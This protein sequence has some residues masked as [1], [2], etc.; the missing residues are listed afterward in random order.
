MKHVARLRL[1]LAACAAAGLL[2]PAAQAETF[3]ATAVAGHPEVFLWV[4]TLSDTLIP[5]VSEQLE[6]TEHSINWME[7]YG[8]TLASVGGEL[9]AIEGGLAQIGIVSSLFEPSLLSLQNVSYATPFGPADVDIVF[10]TVDEMHEEIPDM[11]ALWEE[12]DMEYLGGG[13]GLEDYLLMTDFPVDSLDDLQGRKINAPGPAVNWLKGTGAVG[14]SGNLT[15][16][17]NDIQTGV[18]EGVIVFPTAAAAAKLHEVAPY[19]TRVGFG[20][21]YA[22]AIVAKKSW[23][24]ELPVEVQ[25]ALRGGVDAF[26]VQYRQ[27]LEQRVAA[28]FDTMQSG[29][30]EI[31]E[32]PADERVKWANALPDIAGNWAREQNEKGLAGTEVVNT[33]M[34]KLQEAG[35]DLP[36]D[37]TVE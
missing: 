26:A 8:G 27:G 25:D 23:F 17:Y 10:D 34:Q 22:G 29:G 3:N 4:K 1:G 9:E 21:Q 28:A 12:Y 35:V 15:S 14:V 7:A 6:G 33:Y 32:F 36:R 13:F 30:A 18:A 16:Y 37:W 31:T 11:K 24:D 20:A 5:T 19:V 2:A